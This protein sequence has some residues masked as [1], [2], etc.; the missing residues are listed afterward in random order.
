[1]AATATKLSTTLII[2][3]IDGVDSKGKDII[4][5]QSF[6]KAKVSAAEQDLFD[7][8]KEVEKLIGKTL[9]QVLREDQS[10]ITN[11]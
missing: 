4:K 5:S 1:M 7:V 8:A 2:K 11:R 10:V 6:S 9:D 3:Y